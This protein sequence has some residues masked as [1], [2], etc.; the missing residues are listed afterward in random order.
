LLNFV[1]F[2]LRR[3][4]AARLAESA[5][6]RYLRIVSTVA[7]IIAA[8]EKLPQPEKN[9]L[10]ER[11]RGLESASIKKEQQPYRVQPLPL[12]IRSDKLPSHLLEEL[13]DEEFLQKYRGGK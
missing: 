4:T 1:T 9:E 8:V 7:E 12:G 11:L 3:E 13:D 5:A 2:W 6:F 10:L